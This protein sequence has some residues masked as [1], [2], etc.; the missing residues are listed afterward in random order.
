MTRA[1]ARELGP[2]G[3]HRQRGGARLHRHRH[4]RAACPRRSLERDG[5]PHRRPAPRAA[6]GGRGGLPVPRL[7]RRVVHQRRG[8]GRGRRPAPLSRAGG[9]GVR[10]SPSPRGWPSGLLADQPLLYTHQYHYFTNAP[11]HRAAPRRRWRTCSAA[12]SGGPGTATGRSRRS[13]TCS[14]PRCSG[15]FGRAPRAAA[16]CC[17]ACSTRWWRWRWRP[18]AAAWPARAGPGRASPTRCTGRRWRCRCWTMTENLH[19]PLFVAGVALLAGEPARPRRLAG[20]RAGP[21]PLRPGALRLSGFIGLAAAWR[22]WCGGPARG[23]RAWARW[24]PAAARP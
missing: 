8:G 9:G 11:A 17:S 1:W 2:H 5:R 4:G 3:H 7:R 16:R 24:S 20:R 10:S 22:W 13:I 21:R 18:W 15:S 23:L 12:T 14:W 19:T 6:G